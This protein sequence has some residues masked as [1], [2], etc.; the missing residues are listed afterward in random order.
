L[1]LTTGG[2]KPLFDILRGDAKLTAEGQIALQE[3][4]GQQQIH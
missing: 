4:I 3:A 1:K 2:L